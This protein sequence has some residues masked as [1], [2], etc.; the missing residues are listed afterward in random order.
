MP[1]ALQNL[2]EDP[3]L[4][5]SYY[6]GDLLDVVLNCKTEPVLNEN[7]NAQ[8]IKRICLAASQ[9][10]FCDDNIDCPPTDL[11]VQITSFWAN[12]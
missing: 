3:L 10:K 9:M 8:R 11:L 7:E 2:E 12:G 5:G 4:E 6:P 1:L